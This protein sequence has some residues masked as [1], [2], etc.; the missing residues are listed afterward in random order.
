V[1]GPEYPPPPEDPFM[2]RQLASLAQSVLS[3]QQ[4]SEAEAAAAA[5]EGAP[6]TSSS[7]AGGAKSG[8]GGAKGGGARLRSPEADRA[9]LM[10]GG[11]SSGVPSAISPNPPL[12]V[13]SMAPIPPSTRR[14]LTKLEGHLYLGETASLMFEVRGLVMVEV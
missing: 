7:K 10:G 1:A 9:S 4:A 5:A 12:G 8:A 3:S 6:G 2:E 13:V 11:L 14:L